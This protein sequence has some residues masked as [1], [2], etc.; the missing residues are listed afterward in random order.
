[1][2]ETSLCRSPM[3]TRGPGVLG[4]GVH[5]PYGTISKFPAVLGTLT[6]ARPSRAP[7]SAGLG[8]GP[9]PVSSCGLQVVCPNLRFQFTLHRLEMQD[10]H[11]L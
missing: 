1:M 8:L 3:V 11:P 10:H 2:N 6:A 5:G 4:L 9:H 7:Q